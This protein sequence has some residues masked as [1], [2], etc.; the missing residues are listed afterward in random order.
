MSSED[1]V[2]AVHEERARIGDVELAKKTI[3]AATDEGWVHVLF[4]CFPVNN[5]DS[6]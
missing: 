1:A 6:K 3:L 5:F 2:I 4:L